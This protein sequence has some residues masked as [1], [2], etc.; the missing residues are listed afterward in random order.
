VQYSIN[1][2]GGATIIQDCPFF[3]N[4]SVEKDERRCQGI[5]YCEYSDSTYINT[6]HNNI[7]VDSD[8]YP[9]IESKCKFQRN[10]IFCS[11]SAKLGKIVNHS[12]NITLLDALHISKMTITRGNI[13]E[14]PCSVHFIKIIPLDISSCPY[15]A[16]IC[17]G[18]HEHLLPPPEKIPANLKISLQNLIK[19]AINNNETLNPS[20]KLDETTISRM[21]I[22]MK[23]NVPVTQRDNGEIKR[24]AAAMTRKS[25]VTTHKKATSSK[26][27]KIKSE[28]ND[29]HELEIEERKIMIKERA[30]VIREKEID[31]RKKEAEVEALELANNK[32][33]NDLERVKQA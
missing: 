1:G 3:G 32:M 11:G 8:L 28:A 30:V 23:F 18:T 4:I 7:D 21:Q 26:K 13:I 17:I 24:K 22:H 29:L 14:K 5:K 12:A 27:P 19:Q 25:A 16:L 15:I 9:A 20:R 2:R 31:I 33:R 6:P 10:G